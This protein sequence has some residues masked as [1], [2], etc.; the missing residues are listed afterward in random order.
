[1]GF[2]GMVN[3]PHAGDGNYEDREGCGT[4]FSFTVLGPSSLNIAE[5]I[6]TV[7]VRLLCLLY[8]LLVAASVR[9]WS[10]V[11]R[12]LPGFYVCLIVYVLEV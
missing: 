2:W 5:V 3:T 7:D 1:M 12:V 10:V 9:G 4:V 11:Q 6:E 8:L